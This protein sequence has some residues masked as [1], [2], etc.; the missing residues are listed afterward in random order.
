MAADDVLEEASFDAGYSNI[1]TVPEDQTSEDKSTRKHIVCFIHD[2]LP[3]Q[4]TTFQ[5][6]KYMRGGVMKRR[7]VA[8]INMKAMVGT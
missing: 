8:K 3:R 7:H 5:T 6:P 4:L 1:C 2:R